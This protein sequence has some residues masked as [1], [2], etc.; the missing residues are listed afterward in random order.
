MKINRIEVSNFKSFSHIDIDLRNL[1]IVVGTNAAGKSNFI[2]IFKFL[3]NVV[4]YN[5]NDA[6]SMEGGVEYFRNIQLGNQQNLRFKISYNPERR[7]V[8]QKESD[9]IGVEFCDA[10]YEFEI[11]FH[12]KGKGYL[13]EKD[14]LTIYM[15]FVELVE[16]P[17]K[18]IEEASVIGRGQITYSLNKGKLSTS[19]DVPQEVSDN[20]ILRQLWPFAAINTLGELPPK[21]LLLETP[22]FSFAHNWLLENDFGEIVIYDFDPKLSQ[23]S[24]AVTGK[25]ELEEDGSNLSL[26]LNKILGHRESRRKF[27]NLAS[28]LLKFVSDF[29]VQRQTDKSLLLTLQETYTPNVYLPA[30]LLSDG[31]INVIALIIA[32]YFDERSIVILEEPERNLHPSLIHKIV[33][34]FEEVSDSKQIFVTTHNPELVKAANI[35]DLIFI[36]RAEDGS[37]ITSHPSEQKSVNVFLENDLGIEDLFV[38]DLLGV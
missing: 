16:K 19:Q 18:K 33:E 14:D 11:R 4:K 5:L 15:R 2:R 22:V 32:L 38:D 24:V 28:E 26:I 23:K 10:T 13:I 6:I 1:N 3:R 27:L 36:S 7:T 31:T 8:M 20:T 9:I 35:Q 21:S 30:F 17:P 34:M 29:S 25:S 12:K 37:S